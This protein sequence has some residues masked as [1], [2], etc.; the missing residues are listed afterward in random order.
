MDPFEGVFEG[1]DELPNLDFADLDDT[2]VDEVLEDLNYSNNNVET[3]K[4]AAM[5]NVNSNLNANMDNRNSMNQQE[6]PLIDLNFHDHGSPV[7]NSSS[8][9]TYSNNSPSYWAIFRHLGPE[10]EFLLPFFCQ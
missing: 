2:F 6:Q 5:A 3:P 1:D 9:G 10:S 8:R 7:S 4:V